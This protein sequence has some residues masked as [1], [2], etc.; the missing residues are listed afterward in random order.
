M[1]VNVYVKHVIVLPEDRANEEMA[2]G[3][4]NHYQVQD[5]RIQVVP[6][7]G[8]WPNVLK[9]FEDEYVRRLRAYEAEHLVMLID[10]D[11]KFEVQKKR[12]DE[13]VPADVKDRV[14]VIG[15]SETVFNSIS[16]SPGACW[17]G[18]SC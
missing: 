9:V 13:T 5:A 11:E 17:R 8:G 16:P 12:F 2:N 15:S 4:V 6:P 1:S 10:F 14:F 18:R 7:A 3:F